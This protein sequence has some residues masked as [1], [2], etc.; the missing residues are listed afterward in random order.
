MCEDNRAPLEV[1][2]ICG[3]SDNAH[4]LVDAKCS[5]CQAR[6][7]ETREELQAAGW[8][9]A[10]YVPFSEHEGF[11]LCESCAGDVYYWEDLY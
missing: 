7:T 4:E 5:N 8:R 2:S 1:L 6:R 11:C 9:I 10:M 3:S